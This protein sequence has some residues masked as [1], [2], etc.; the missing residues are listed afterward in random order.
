MILIN[1]ILWLTGLVIFYCI[2]ERAIT[3]GVYLAMKR[4][5]EEKNKNKET[6]IQ[7]RERVRRESNNQ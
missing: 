6:M 7:I 2:L 4:I 1:I 3:N 5:E